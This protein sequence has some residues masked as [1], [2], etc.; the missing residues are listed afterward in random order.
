MM[1]QAAG[2]LKPR[3]PPKEVSLFA[4]A[5]LVY[6][7]SPTIHNNPDCREGNVMQFFRDFKLSNLSKISARFAPRL[8]ASTS[9]ATMLVAGGL[10]AQAGIINEPD[11]A[12]GGKLP[13]NIKTGVRYWIELNRQGKTFRVTNQQKF[14]SGDRIRFH[15]QPTVDGF[16]YI[17]LRSGSQGEQAVLFPLEKSKD[18]NRLHREVDYA[19]PADDFLTF[20]AHPGT[21]K[22]T[23]LFSKRALDQSKVVAAS[24]DGANHVVVGSAAPG[25]KDL[26]PA[27]TS[28]VY[29]PAEAI[30]TTIE[31]STKGSVADAIA[32]AEAKT[33]DK[34][35]SVPGSKS[36]N[37][38]ESKPAAT[39]TVAVKPPAD[40]AP[41]A[42][43]VT[44]SA[45]PAP[46]KVESKK[47]DPVLAKKTDAKSESKIEAKVENKLASNNAKPDIQ[48]VKSTNGAV[49]VRQDD[50][51]RVLHIDVDLEHSGS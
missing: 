31:E 30:S 14:I 28:V 21:E 26:I 29:Q 2:E 36:S 10:V 43:A 39:T 35:G 47:E 48:T 27:H 5:E 3:R 49:L 11:P 32:Q 22:V 1:S 16:A 6:I 40:S 13:T 12:L 17:V 41:Q 25:S 15:V 8:L 46:P 34:I 44:E 33:D 38:I 9:L 24:V 7:C 23:L 19:L 42:P 51:D 50:P 45:P 20:D 18:D 37:E 4:I